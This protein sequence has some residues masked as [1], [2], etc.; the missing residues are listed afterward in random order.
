MKPPPTIAQSRVRVSPTTPA[1]YLGR[2]ARWWIDG[3]RHPRR[4]S[5]GALRP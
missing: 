3:L 2:S 5:P 1:Y 4:P